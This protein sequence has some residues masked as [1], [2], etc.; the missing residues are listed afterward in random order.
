LGRCFCAYQVAVALWITLLMF[1]ISPGSGNMAKQGPSQSFARKPASVARSP[2]PTT[3]H[4]TAPA[5]PSS[6]PAVGRLG[7][8]PRIGPDEGNKRGSS[9]N[10]F[11]NTNFRR[12]STPK[13]PNW[14]AKL[15]LFVTVTLGLGGNAWL[16][17]LSQRARKLLQ[18]KV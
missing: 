8:R 1:V 4:T 9:P 14:T 2:L 7:E 10:I 11:K 13:K 5:S 16:L 12:M 18:R 6:R 15:I 17:Y 3:Q